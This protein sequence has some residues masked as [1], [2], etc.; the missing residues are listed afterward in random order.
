V[1]NSKEDVS[2][3]LKGGLTK[4]IFFYQL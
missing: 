1:I 4:Q 2:T 3:V